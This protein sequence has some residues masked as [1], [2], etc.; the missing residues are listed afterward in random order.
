[1][2]KK[3][4]ATF[5]HLFITQEAMLRLKRKRMSNTAPPPP[6]PTPTK[7]HLSQGKSSVSKSNDSRSA[8]QVPQTTVYLPGYSGVIWSIPFLWALL[9]GQCHRGKKINMIMRVSVLFAL[10]AVFYTGVCVALTR[11]QLFETT[12]IKNYYQHWLCY[13]YPYCLSYHHVLL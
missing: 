2:Q 13:I 1:M 11:A 12:L 9:S 8:L 5:L 10:L 4:E 7:N 6:S 3:K